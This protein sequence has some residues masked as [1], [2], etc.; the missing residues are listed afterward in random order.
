[1]ETYWTL[2]SAFPGSKLRLTKL[3]DAIYAH[4]RREFPDLDVKGPLDEDAMK[5]KDGKEKWRKFIQEYENTVE[6]YN[7]GCMVRS[8]SDGEYG[9]RSTIFGGFSAR[10]HEWERFWL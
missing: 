3:D 5:S 2:L 8:R 6:D 7:F 4:F 10:S 9:E 1:M